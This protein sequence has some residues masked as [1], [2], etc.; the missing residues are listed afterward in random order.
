MERLYN[1]CLEDHGTDDPLFDW[2]VIEAKEGGETEDNKLDIGQVIHV[3]ERGRD[4]LGAVI[5][6]LW[7]LDVQ[8]PDRQGCFLCGTRFDKGKGHPVEVKG[9][10]AIV[11]QGPVGLLCDECKAGRD[12]LEKEQ[13]K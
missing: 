13:Q 2:I 10:E 3:L 8:D 5:Q 6:A 1:L 11:A 9:A 7:Q 4:K 12:E